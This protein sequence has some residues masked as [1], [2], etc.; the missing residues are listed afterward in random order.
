MHDPPASLETV[1]PGNSGWP[2]TPTAA[3]WRDAGA[4][5]ARVH[6]VPLQPQEHLRL[7]SGDVRSRPIVSRATPLLQLADEV[8][9]RHEPPR[10][11]SVFMHGDVW[12]GNLLWIGDMCVGVID[13]KEARVGDPGSVVGSLGYFGDLLV[14]ADG[15]VLGLIG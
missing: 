10:G 1:L 9:R 8:L 12:P 5:I 4:A 7:R 11:E 15:G 14:G 6:R 2:K 13:W 3:G